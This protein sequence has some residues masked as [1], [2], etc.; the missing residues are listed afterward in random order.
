MT[1]LA[2]IVSH[3]YSPHRPVARQYPYILLVSHL[4]MEDANH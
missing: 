3:F 2:L 1:R 4:G